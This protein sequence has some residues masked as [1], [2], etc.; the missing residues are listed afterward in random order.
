M[1]HNYIKNIQYNIRL[2]YLLIILKNNYL[3]K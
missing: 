3:F 2:K 1:Q